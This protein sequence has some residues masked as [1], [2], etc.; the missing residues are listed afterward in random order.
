MNLSSY[1]YFKICITFVQTGSNSIIIWRFFLTEFS[2]N[3]F[4][5]MQRSRYPN[6]LCQC[7][8]HF[9]AWH[10]SLFA[11]V[12]V[13]PFSNHQPTI[14]SPR[15]FFVQR[16]MGRLDQMVLCTVTNVNPLS[17]LKLHERFMLPIKPIIL[18]GKILTLWISQREIIRSASHKG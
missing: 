17:C 12:F 7:F 16:A 14:P 2:C 6:C 15:F 8:A 1:F 5:S 11:F 3:T 18:L 9:Q 10:S 4:L 13:V